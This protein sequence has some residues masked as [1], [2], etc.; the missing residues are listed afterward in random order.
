MNIS[1]HCHLGKK[2]VMSM[3]AWLLVSESG[4]PPGNLP[5]FSREGKANLLLGPVVSEN[6]R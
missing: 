5:Q 1:V 3:S 6:E 2:I 4:G